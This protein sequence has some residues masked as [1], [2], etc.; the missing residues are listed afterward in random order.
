VSTLTRDAAVMRLRRLDVT[1]SSADTERLL[2]DASHAMSRYSGHQRVLEAMAL[3]LPLGEVLQRLVITLEE[4]SPDT[5]GSVLLLDDAG[6][7]VL[8]GAAPNLPASYSA[9]IHGAP[10]GPAAGSCGTAAWRG[11]LVVVPDIATDPLWAD[12]TELALSHGLAACWSAPIKDRDGRVLG[13]FAQYAREPRAPTEAELRVLDDARDVASVALQLAHTESTLRAV[14]EQLQSAQ[15]LEAVGRLAGGIAHDFNNLLTVV[16]G[17]LSLALADVPP[18]SAQR[19]ALEEA[20]SATRRASAL[21]RQLLTFSRRE[22]VTPEVLDLVQQVPA[23][24]AD[25]RTTLGD[26]VSLEFDLATSPCLVRIDR[27]HLALALQ[28]LLANAREAM[29][30]GGRITVVVGEDAG[31]EG[32]SNP[33]RGRVAV[34]AVRDNGHG[35]DEATRRRV[36]E[37]LF[38]TKPSGLGLGLGLP[39]VHAIVTRHAG[40]VSIESAPG[41]G[42]TVRVSLPT[43]VAEGPLVSTRPAPSDAAPASR[44]ERRGGPGTI[45]LVEDEDSVRRLTRRVLVGAGYAVLEARDGVEA[46][47]VWRTHRDAITSLVTDVMMPRLGGAALAVRLRAE[48]AELPV[49]FCSGYTDVFEFDMAQPG[50]P[51]VFLAKPFTV[52]ALTE[53][54]AELRT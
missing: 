3:R 5:M 45:L 43:H 44:V 8:T 52:Q 17:N 33:S 21:A 49:L 46:L 27:T 53:K 16:G 11:A 18:A 54:M 22:P 37:P 51:T 29:P 13:T 25:A 9:A 28:A 38:S 6:T 19:E 39:T 26:G 10:I 30:N 7:H 40:D 12:Y 50:A 47:E 14:S 31:S 20:Q 36:F 32:V 15:R 35:M 23:L 48:R 2:R 4:A 34:L 1:T 24:L 42:C 41:A